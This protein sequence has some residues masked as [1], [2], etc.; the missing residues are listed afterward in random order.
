MTLTFG[1][2][3]RRYLKM[4]GEETIKVITFTGK[5]VDWENFELK[6]TARASRKG[7]LKVLLQIVKLLNDEDYKKKIVDAKAT[8]EEVCNMK[9]NAMAFEDLLLSI[10]SDNTEGKAALK[11]LKECVGGEYENVIGDAGKAWKLLKDKY[12]KKNAPNYLKLKNDF[13]SRKL[14]ENENPEEWILDLQNINLEI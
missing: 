7:Y 8:S 12:A 13:N 6:F 11:L 14:K 5:K 1:S 3:R 4:S 10:K 2:V 9:L